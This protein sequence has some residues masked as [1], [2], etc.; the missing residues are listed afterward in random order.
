MNWSTLSDAELINICKV[1]IDDIGHHA[2][3]GPG[4]GAD[5]FCLNLRAWLGERAGELVHRL[6]SADARERDLQDRVTAMTKLQADEL[7]LARGVGV[8][9]GEGK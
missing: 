3:P 4:E 8:L 7:A 6:E 1:A 9:I 5:Y 2:H